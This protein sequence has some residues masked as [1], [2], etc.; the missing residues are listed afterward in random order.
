MTAGIFGYSWFSN[1]ETRLVDAGTG[2]ITLVDGD[3][4]RHIFGEIAGGGYVAAGGIYLTLVKNGDATYTITQADGTK[5]NYNTSGKVASIVDTTSFTYD[6]NGK[7]TTIQDASGRTTSL[8]YGTNGYV[9]SITD[10]ANRTVAYEYDVNGN[11][12]KVTDTAGKFTTY[13]YDATHN[14]TGITN[15]RNITTTVG[16]GASDRVANVNRPITIDG[17]STTSTTNYVFDI[18]NKVTTVTDGEGRRVDY[19]YNANGNIVQVTENPLDA[20]NKAITTFDYDNNNNLTQVKDPNTNKISGTSAYIYTYDANGNITE[21]QLPEN[22]RASNTYDTN[23]NLISATDYNRNT[24]S[25]SYDTKNN[26]T[27]ATD[28]NLQTSATRYAANGNLLNYTNTMSAADNLIPNSGFEL[29]NDANNWPDNWTKSTEPNKTAT[30]AWSTTAKLGQKSVSV[31]NP[32][33]WA[34]VGTDLFPYTAG[35]KYVI[36]GYVKTVATT[37]TAVVKLAFYDANNVW[38]DQQTAYQLKGTND[39]T[40]VQAVIDSVP[41]NTAKIQLTVGLNAGSGTAYFDGIQL[42]KGTTL[43]AY[44]L[45]DNSSLERDANA[46]NLPDNWTTSGNL[47]VNDKMDENVNPDDDKVIIEICGIFQSKWFC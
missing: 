25:S 23:N 45:I 19:T 7:L 42:E 30:Y 1:L 20:Q 2:P 21:V 17:V 6:G 35:D 10:P 27:E 34:I 32:T 4:T 46:D 36:S 37:N 12:T 28:P 14:L 3:N 22:Q 29:D 8:V 18:T 31:S 44:N 24:S 39:W 33:G 5:V 43:S 15:P 13:G 47:S 9:S 26:K 40:R 41:A 16:Y 38:I 11:L